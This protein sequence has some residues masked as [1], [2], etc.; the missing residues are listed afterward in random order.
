MKK[1]L[2]VS[3]IIPIYNQEEYLEKSLLAASQQTYSNIEIIAVNDGSTDKSVDILNK[4]MELEPRLKII[5]QENQGLVKATVTGIKNSIGDY[6]CFLDPDDTIGENFVNNFMNELDELYDFIAAGYYIDNGISK[7]P[8]KLK[9]NKI[10]TK[11]ELYGSREYVL[12]EKNIAII[13]NEFFISRWNKI[14][15]R[16]CVNTIVNEFEKYEEV[17]LGEDTIFNFLIISNSKSGKTIEQPNEY[18]YNVYNQNSMMKNSNVDAYFYKCSTA[19]ESFSELLNKYGCT[20]RQA[21]LLFYFLIDSLFKRLYKYDLESFK[22]MYRKLI[23]NKYNKKAMKIVSYERNSLKKKIDIFIRRCVK[24]P[25]TYLK[26]VKNGERGKNI[27][28]GILDDIRLIKRNLFKNKIL[29]IKRQLKFNRER[30][31]AFEDINNKLPILEAR[32]LP[33]LKLYIGKNT[34]LKNSSIERNIFVFWWDGFE[35]APEIVKNCLKS[36]Y[37]KYKD[38]N[39][40]QISKNN[41][42]EYTDINPIIIND[43]KDGRI[44]VQ[45]FSDILRF[46]LLKNNGGM[47]IDA[48]IFFTSKCD[49]FQMMENQSFN[50]LSFC[51]SNNFLSYKGEVCSWSGYF[52][53]SRKGSLLVEAINYIFEQ[54]YIDYNEYTTYFFIDAVLILCKIYGI[55]DN[56]LKKS[57]YIEGDMFLLAPLLDEQFDRYQFEKISI[58]PQKLMWFYNSQ[59]IKGSYYERIVKG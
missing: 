34:D 25:N 50:T 11:E 47:W 23:R 27:C 39:I 8:I 44:S 16:E 10:Y 19:F 31:N 17:S 57:Y 43:F 1:N 6:I 7:N 54:Y 18:F 29:N 45:T 37:E 4:F 21:Y 41:Y 49:L 2:R 59:N 26:V 15:S 14:Y 22:Y 51:S 55:D 42:K 20:N 53:A 28:K 40:V 48:T 3:I 46:N 36:I 33:Y 56:V 35:N 9:Q 58:I 52:I 13:S 30:R 12:A 38:E 5:H 24:K 32:I